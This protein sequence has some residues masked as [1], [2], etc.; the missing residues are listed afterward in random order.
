MKRCEPWAKFLDSAPTRRA[1]WEGFKKALFAH[2]TETRA[3]GLLPPGAPAHLTNHSFLVSGH[4]PARDAP[5]VPEQSRHG[6]LRAPGVQCGVQVSGTVRARAPLRPWSTSFRAPRRLQESPATAVCTAEFTDTQ[7][8]AMWDE[9]VCAGENMRFL[10]PTDDR[11]IVA[12]NVI[13]TPA[14]LAPVPELEKYYFRGAVFRRGWICYM[15][16]GRLHFG[17]SHPSS[18]LRIILFY[19]AGIYDSSTQDTRQNTI[20]RLIPDKAEGLQ[21]CSRSV[22]AYAEALTYA[23]TKC[24]GGLLEAQPDLKDVA[25]V[26]VPPR[27]VAAMDGKRTVT[28][29]EVVKKLLDDVAGL[30]ATGDWKQESFEEVA[31]RFLTLSEKFFPPAAEE[32]QKK[33]K[34]ARRS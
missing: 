11:G 33:S 34:R 1:L 23:L 20:Y 21:R 30:K 31:E 25:V 29:M 9:Y 26:K 7:A 6:D 12:A 4:K 14:L 19:V 10:T 17:P 32:R 2:Y 18:K 8:Q 15:Q 3:G 28:G 24:R 27:L 22:W 16:G 5:D 13:S